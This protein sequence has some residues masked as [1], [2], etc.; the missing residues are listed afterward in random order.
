MLEVIIAV[1]EGATKRTKDEGLR[2]IHR[3]ATLIKILLV[4][5]QELVRKGV[6]NLLSKE[7]TLQV[8]GEAPDGQ[9]A[10]A[11]LPEKKPDVVLLDL[12]LPDTNGMKLTEKLLRYS[13][14]LKI[15]ILTANVNSFFPFRLMEMG[16]HGYLTKS[17]SVDELSKAI[18]AVHK[19]ER[20]L[21]PDIAK[22]LALANIDHGNQSVFNT[23][24][25]KEMEVMLLLAR[26]F[27]PRQIAERLF[28]SAK[29]VHSYRSRI[30]NKIGVTN[31]VELIIKAINHQ[32]VVPEELLEK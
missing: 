10:L 5:D 17:A 25:N 15:I 8:V 16:V 31:D 32:I 14:H 24:S 27:V 20:Y 6:L 9:T 7:K 21:S 13:D 19:G 1:G 29:T 18:F 26:G 28:L 23:L 3:S 4:E 11:M 12:N 22:R 30:Y 2:H